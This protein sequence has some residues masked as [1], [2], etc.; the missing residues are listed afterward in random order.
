MGAYS[1]SIAA[2]AGA[3]VSQ[4]YLVKISGSNVIHTTAATDV[5]YGVAQHSASASG[6]EI[7]VVVSGR[8]KVKLSGTVAVGAILQPSTTAGTVETHS[9][10][11]VRVARAL[12]AGVSGDVIWCEVFALPT[13]P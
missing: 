6:D 8:S 11:N 9:S 13:A 12:E 7:N 2:T 5:S 3:A 1:N 4:F 10:T